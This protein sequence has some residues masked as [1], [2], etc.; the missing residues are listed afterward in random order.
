MDKKH[1][2][3]KNNDFQTKYKRVYRFLRRNGFSIRS[4]TH[5]GRF[6][7][8][9]SILSLTNGSKKFIKKGSWLNIQMI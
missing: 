2:E 9:N 3:L 7:P 6:I 4:L 1:P 8:F 5:K